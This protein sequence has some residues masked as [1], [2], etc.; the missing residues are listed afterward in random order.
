MSSSGGSFASIF[1]LFA[2][3]YAVSLFLYAPKNK[4][5]L[6]IAFAVPLIGYASA[7]R[8]IWFFY[9]MV[10]LLTYLSYLHRERKFFNTSSFVGIGIMV[11]VL[12]GIFLYGI[13]GASGLYSA[14]KTSAVENIKS[15]TLY[16]REYTLEETYE[17]K[18]GGRTGT[19]LTVLK[20]IK[21]L[22]MQRIMF[23][24]GP[25]SGLGAGGVDE[26]NI[27]YG[28]VGWASDALFV[29]WPAAACYILFYLSLWYHLARNA[30]FTPSRMGQ[31]L[32]LGTQMGFVVFVICHFFYSSQWKMWGTLPFSH[33][34]LLGMLISPW[35]R[36]VWQQEPR[37]K[38]IMT[39]EKSANMRNSIFRKQMRKQNR[40]P[41]YF[42]LENPNQEHF[43]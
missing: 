25:F 3:A 43:K 8:A 37:R 24:L 36:W 16:A 9:P 1:P 22:D 31:G 10:M 6:V 18:T 13:R 35:H 28:I 29:G 19:S 23:G 41:G 32:Y 38:T 33:M 27:A 42:S 39:P 26:L 34:C 20:S 5:L 17:G 15:A 4:W 12:M 7:K 40:I 11:L 2:G 21:E 14:E 30:R